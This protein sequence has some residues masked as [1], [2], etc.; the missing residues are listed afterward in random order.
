MAFQPPGDLLGAPL[1]PDQADG[2]LE[3]LIGEIPAAPGYGAA[4][5]GGI[6]GLSWLVTATIAVALEFAT[7]G[8][9]ISPQLATYLGIGKPLQTQGLKHI[10][11]SRGELVVTHGKHPVP[12]RRECFRIPQLASPTETRIGKNFGVALTL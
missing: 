4:S 5:P 11:F 3:L 9:A 2:D 6:V 8:R 7:D 12:P 1:Q 10:S